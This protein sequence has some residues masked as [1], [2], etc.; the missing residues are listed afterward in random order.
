MKTLRSLTLPVPVPVLLNLADGLAGALS[1]RHARIGVHGGLCPDV[2]R[3]EADGRLTVLDP[4]RPLPQRALYAAPE[5]S[6]QLSRDVDERADLYAL[7]AIL[8]E[9]A[10]GQLPFGS[11]RSAELVRAQLSGAPPAA[12]TARP[13]LP[14]GL[15]GVLAALLARLPEDRYQ[16]AGGV[17]ADVHT[18]LEELQATGEIGAFPPA[19]SDVPARLAFTGRLYGRRSRLSQLVSARER[20][21]RDG[22]VELVPV[23]ADPGLGKSALLG[24][25][26]DT[27]VMEG[28]WVARTAFEVTEPAPYAALARLLSDLVE[29]L[30]MRCG[31]DVASWR[32]QLVED[33]GGTAPVLAEFVPE[34]RALFGGEATG[35]PAPPLGRRAESLLRLG[36]RRLLSS[37]SGAAPPLVLILDDLHRADADSVEV[38]RY[39]LSDPA[40][41]G[42]LVVVALRPKEIPEPVNALL[43]ELGPVRSG[44]TLSLRPLPDSALTELLADTLR[45]GVREAS[46]LARVVADKTGSRPLAVAEFLRGVRDN[47]LL[48]FDQ[49]ANA[50][51]WE[52]IDLAD[53]PAVQDVLPAIRGRLGRLPARVL[54]LLQVATILGGGVLDAAVL[55]KV[56]GLSPDA[57]LDLLR[58]AIRE[59]LLAVA[60]GT[61]RYRWPHEVVRRAVGATLREPDRG[62]LAAAVARVLLPD[63]TGADAH[64]VVELCPGGPAGAQPDRAQLAARALAAG[65]HAF[66]IGA[67]RVARGRMLAA[68]DLLPPSGWA[69]RP[70]LAYAVHLHAAVTS[71]EAGDLERADGLLGR[72]SGYAADDLAR[73]EVLAIRARWRRA[74]GQ[75]ALSRTA[76]RQALDL[77]GVA[78]PADA[79]R[80]AAAARTAAAGLTRRLADVDVE[81]FARGLTASDPRVIL[82]L[83]VIADAVTLDDPT[84]DWGALLAATGVRLAFD[85][86]PTPA[87]AAAFAGHAAALARQAGHRDP[88]AGEDGTGA[89]CAAGIA[90]ALVDRCPAPGY[91]ARVSPV[92]AQVRALW[93]DAV[94]SPVVHLDRGYRTGIEDGEPVL[95]LDNLVLAIAHRFVLGAPLGALADEV[96]MLWRLAD[97]YGARERV[98]VAAEALAEAIARL[99]G[100]PVGA[101]ASPGGSTVARTVG[102]VTACLVG[103]YPR[104]LALAPAPEANDGSFLAAVAAFYHA[105]A[106]AA[107]YRA[108]SPDRQEAILARL[109]EAQSML[110]EWASH[111]PGAFDA[112]AT[113]LAAERARLSGDGEDAEARYPR[114][115]DTARKQ[116][117]GTVEALAAEL[118]GRYALV[119]GDTATAVAHLRRARDCYHRWGAPV[120]VANVDAALAA[121]PTRPHR[122]FDQLDL[123][124]IVRAFQAIA[125]ELSVDR[126]VVTLLNLLLEH[127]HAERGALL[128]PADGGLRLAATARVERGGI[129]VVA[130]PKRLTAERVPEAVVEHVHRRRQPLGGRPEPPGSAPSTSTCS[131]CCARKPRSRWTTPRCTPG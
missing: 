57:L 107:E 22:G 53:A 18:C 17:L 102:L 84:D 69:R 117:L 12:S 98:A 126:L 72:A 50:W 73:A 35:Y 100:S 28:G 5:Q 96:E 59:G 105:V 63:A 64:L 86:G 79:P 109:R 14:P 95:A 70:P 24:A 80:W 101:P 51:R 85:F 13:D 4:Q 30:T 90:L 110:D 33:L 10:T 74:D 9:L 26:S 60:P 19:R 38:L 118:G 7:G 42:L 124:A 43:R 108:A 47:R 119:H 91:A 1:R 115:V 27:V 37:V 11:A 87:A 67:V 6:G 123:L 2:V 56:T 65:Q 89:A 41:T 114:A 54:Q 48:L 49:R 122:T 3:L 106:L 131:T 76:A 103:D 130:E 39:A 120:L 20:V 52:R 113:L 16:S 8:Y 31:G 36:I 21:A 129:T 32:A 112:Y 111:G 71:H 104:A 127:T 46:D 29:H 97:R 128:L 61:G 83:D 125:G 75:F 45:A 121:V 34:L 15:D 25:F 81:E 55:G 58:V 88:V 40:S 92:V 77:L 23:S 94:V 68:V 93:Y 62:A 66:R 44:G 78:L 99:D 82:A 116:S